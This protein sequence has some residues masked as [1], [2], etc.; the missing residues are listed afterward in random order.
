MSETASIKVL[1]RFRPIN[2]REQQEFITM[3]GKDGDS[4][5]IAHFTDEQ[6]VELDT[7]GAQARKRYIFDRIFPM[8]ST[9][10]D[11]YSLAAYDIVNQMLVGYSACMFT[12][13]QTS[14]GKSYSMFG[15]DIFDPEMK[16]IIPR[17]AEHI[18][19][20]IAEA[21][22]KAEGGNIDFTV[23][24]SF[25]EIYN[26]RIKDLL[27][28]DHTLIPASPQA[29]AAAAA[30]AAA[31]ADPN[32][33]P[34]R[35]A[36]QPNR[37]ISIAELLKISNLDEETIGAHVPLEAPAHAHAP[38]SSGASGAPG[39][40]GASGSGVSI[41]GSVPAEITGPGL[42]IRESPSKGVYV[43]GLVEVRVM[44]HKEILAAISIGDL[45]R[46][47]S[48]TSMNSVSSRSHTVLIITV[49]QTN[50]DDSSKK[51]GTLSLIDLAGSE[52]VQ[53]TGAEGQRLVEAKNI[54]RSLTNLGRCIKSIVDNDKHIPYRDSKLTRLLQ[55]SL[56]GNCK[57]TLLLTCSPHP[58]NRDETISTCE[59]GKRAK[60]IKNLVRVNAVK[61]TKELLMMIDR[62]NAQVAR[63]KFY[64]QHLV[65]AL[66]WYHERYG[67]LQQDPGIDS[68]VFTYN[69]EPG[70]TLVWM[71]SLLADV[72]SDQ[73]GTA[74]GCF[75]MNAVLKEE[76][77][78]A[79]PP[80]S[81][82]Q[83]QER[84]PLARVNEDIFVE[85][86]GTGL[87][88][89]MC[90]STNLEGA[91][92]LSRVCSLDPLTLEAQ[93][94]APTPR[95]PGAGAGSAL[96][97]A[98][99]KQLREEAE[100]KTGQLNA[101]SA[102]LES[103]VFHKDAEIDSLGRQLEA[104]A[105]EADELAG[106]LADLQAQGEKIVANYESQIKDMKKRFDDIV[107][108]RDA[109]VGAEQE[110]R[111]KASDAARDRAAVETRQVVAES[112]VEE[113]QAT[114]RE[115]ESHLAQARTERA[116]T[117]AA[118]EQQVDFYRAENRSLCAMLG[119]SD[120]A[121]GAAEGAEGA[122]P[123]SSAGGGGNGNGNG[124]A[125]GEGAP[126]GPAGAAACSP[127]IA[128]VREN[129]R[130]KSELDAARQAILQLRV[131]QADHKLAVERASL[132][133]DR[134]VNAQVLVGTLTQ[135]CEGYA[136]STTLL[137][138]GL[139]NLQKLLAEKE[140]ELKLATE[141]SET[142]QRRLAQ[143][144]HN[145]HELTESIVLLKCEK[146]NQFLDAVKEKKGLLSHISKLEQVMDTSHLLSGAPDASLAKRVILGN[147]DAMR[148]LSEIA[149][150][151]VS[152]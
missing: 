124:S 123:G 17:A 129:Q 36:P 26:E 120:G 67:L 75:K 134:F 69:L 28:R 39:A 147:P 128:A 101:L 30:S 111:A 151:Q 23:K 87:D 139:N 48:S 146:E 107:Q 143:L 58:F 25:L 27:V 93:Q 43:E 144:E 56:G 91:S 103:T 113:L 74:D 22:A 35:R 46:S 104:Q 99:L 61:S 53:K 64:N 60:L 81:Q 8:D 141:I 149:G 42:Q 34:P 150:K 114:V 117:A 59:F 98:E 116:E 145:L 71:E 115:L 51:I 15:A 109:L 96:L 89:S 7:E 135:K 29:A 121:G 126:G 77:R 2:S 14:S 16:G 11:V 70:Y 125:A 94:G 57:T 152:L 5:V 55:E 82:S 132:A 72:V 119:V 13:G 79:Q 50:L 65:K 1:C 45:N 9:Q 84:R 32:A 63:L 88:G 136:Q 24:A 3:G 90:D 100:Q 106:R 92:D 37:L 12:Y 78:L 102:E 127:L 86:T 142:R 140:S 40:P 73:L 95:R 118:L 19:N 85:E 10:H 66:R 33:L 80:P 105:A 138:E 31:P 38:A 4:P 83:S 62:L 47:I 112:K 97:Q 108:Q 6:T 18:F 130:L 137:Q 21:R 76:E 110:L 68:S 133:N 54:N 20:F 131:Q 148:R 44:S 41:S 52:K 122:A 49:V